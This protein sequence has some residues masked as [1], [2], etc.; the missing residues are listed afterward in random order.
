MSINTLGSNRDRLVDLAVE[1]REDLLRAQILVGDPRRWRPRWFDGRFLSAG[2]LLAEQNYFLVRQAD[3]G[4]TAGSGVIDGLGVSINDQPGDNPDQLI[5]APGYGITDTGELVAL[6]DP[7]TIDPADVPEMIRLDAAFGLQ[8]LPGEPSRSRTGLYVLALRPVEWTANPTGAYP[9]SLT[10]P[11]TVEDGTIVEGVAVSLIPYPDTGNDDTW[12]R[13]RARVAREIFVEGKDHGHNSGALPLAM[14]ALRGNLV[15]WV[16]VNLVRRE[17]GSERPAGMDFG[18]GQRALREAHLLQYQA[19]LADVLN[20]RNGGSFTAASAFGALPPV[21][22]FPS[23]SL[24]PETLTQ[25]YFPVGVEVDLSFVPEDELPAL[26]EESLLLPPIDLTASAEQLEGVAVVVLV[27]LSRAVFQ[28]NRGILPDW[29][30][31]PL[32][33]RSPVGSIR[34]L[35]SPKE[36]LTSRLVRPVAPSTPLPATD[37]APWKALLRSSV[38]Q[39]LLWYVRCRYLPG[40][41]NAAATPVSATAAPVLNLSRLALLMKEDAFVQ[42]RIETLKKVGTPQSIT[43]MRR[44]GEAQ[45]LE[46]P[47]VLR[48]IVAKAT[49]GET[50]EATDESIREALA[51]AS[52]PTVGEGLKKLAESDPALAKRFETE[53]VVRSG[54]LTDVDRLVR[55]TKEEEVKKVAKEVKTVVGTRGAPPTDRTEKLVAARNRLTRPTS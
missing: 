54:I 50:K 5:I 35:S 2:D 31:E 32:R 4:R 12:E 20:A 45:V 13:R 48:S 19:H 40:V 8:V 14:V 15:E 52:D 44:L 33:L 22:R 37:E 46:N 30:A 34:S 28:Q 43:L 18:F 51:A 7:L 41:S 53:E 3:M 24:D 47:I 21:G 38:T 1:R 29:D 49:N 42:E 23:S 10:G 26:V 55:E 39:P 6:L 25:R 16:D 27:P 17:T 11:R 36:L 9:T